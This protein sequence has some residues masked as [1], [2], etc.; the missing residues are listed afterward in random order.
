MTKSKAKQRRRA[1][2]DIKHDREGLKAS[3]IYTKK[4]G[5]GGNFTWG[6]PGD[7][8]YIPDVM[9]GD[10]MY[11]SQ[12]ENEVYYTFSYD[13]VNFNP[14]YNFEY[15]K[16]DGENM[17]APKL[18][19]QE[20]KDKIQT[21]IKEL[22]N[23]SDFDEFVERVNQHQ[24]VLLHHAL[25]KKLIELAME[26]SDRERELASQ[27]LIELQI[28][29]ILPF[30]QVA[31]AFE[32][33]FE[34]VGDLSLDIPSAPKLLAQFLAR[35][36]ADDVIPPAFLMDKYIESLAKPIVQHAKVLLSMKHGIGR[37]ERV[38]G[39]SIS[40][41]VDELKDEIKALLMEY[42]N[43]ADSGEVSKLLKKMNIPF[44]HHEVVKRGIML[45][46]ERK[47]REQAMIS[48]L[49][50]QLVEA[51]VISS[52]QLQLG[53]QRLYQELRDIS[54]DN[55]DAPVIIDIFAKQAMKD[56]CLSAEELSALKQK[57]ASIAEKESKLIEEE[58]SDNTRGR[59]DSGPN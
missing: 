14:A 30:T 13:K 15:L 16:Q 39:V 25:V 17:V 46:L 4:G 38:W 37:L 29:S 2:S 27:A 18:S 5:G 12:D 53:F 50:K 6:K 55:P 10:P 31:K 24:S 23:S 22:F 58:F 32:R 42:L 21:D 40:S 56:G 19:L 44:F 35:C 9:K 48:V 52:K 7:E 8:A 51:E 49:M 36:V 33:L 1:G 11:D 54:L 34:N 26:N 20:F 45:A 59:A 41:S 28:A 3:R 43:S 47:E 57:A